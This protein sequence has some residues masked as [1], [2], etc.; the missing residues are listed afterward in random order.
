MKTAIKELLPHLRRFAYS[1]T[2]NVHDAD[3]LVQNTIEKL[4]SLPPAT[5]VPLMQWCFRVCRNAWID[6]YRSRKVR[7]PGAEQVEEQAANSDDAAM[8]LD[9]IQ[10]RQV[11]QAMEQLP[12]EQ[13]EVLGLVAVQGFSYAEAAAVLA[14]PA[15][16]IMSRLA[17]ARASLLQLMPN[18]FGSYSV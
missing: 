14:I 12:D 3:D 9:Q 17:R 10:L 1:L 18:G 11:E 2:G 6:E 7:Q 4:L 8:V 16:T 15:G 5:D 13:R